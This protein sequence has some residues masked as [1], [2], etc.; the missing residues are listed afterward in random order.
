MITLV[1]SMFLNPFIFE[2]LKLTNIVLLQEHCLRI[3]VLSIR[4]MKAF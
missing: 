4:I 1:I 3:A 2:D